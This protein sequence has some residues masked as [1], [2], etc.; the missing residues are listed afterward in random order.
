MLLVVVHL[1]GFTIEIQGVSGGIVNILG[2][3]SFS[4]ALRLNA[5]RGLLILE[6]SRSHKTTNHSR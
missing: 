1:V 6:V 3:F 4:V 2:G 5:G